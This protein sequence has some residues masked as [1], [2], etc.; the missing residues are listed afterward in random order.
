MALHDKYFCNNFLFS[1][2]KYTFDNSFHINK[3]KK[4][5]F[6]EKINL[7]IFILS[8]DNYFEKKITLICEIIKNKMLMI[9]LF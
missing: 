6:L 7:I 8:F 9:K 1:K 2:K 3:K 5:Y 4:I